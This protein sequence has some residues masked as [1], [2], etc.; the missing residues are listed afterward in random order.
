MKLDLLFV[1]NNLQETSA[2]LFLLNLKCTGLPMCHSSAVQ[3][4]Q[5][6]LNILNESGDRKVSL[7]WPR[8]LKDTNPAPWIPICLLA[9]T[10]TNSLN[11]VVFS[12]WKSNVF[13]INMTAFPLCF[14]NERELNHIY[15]N[16][17][18]G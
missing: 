3:K 16:T 12:F 18:F 17:L 2:F 1:K 5:L 13:Q 15:S 10:L 9:H 11:V 6:T 4:T 8:A 14:R 7:C